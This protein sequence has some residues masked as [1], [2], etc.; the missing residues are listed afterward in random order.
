MV[1]L[2]LAL[3]C[4]E[5][6]QVKCPSFRTLL[7]GL[8]NLC[9]EYLRRS[10]SRK[11][12]EMTSDFLGAIFAPGTYVVAFN[13]SS[14]TTGLELFTLANFRANL[15]ELYVAVGTDASSFSGVLACPLWLK[16]LSF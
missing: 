4:G 11:P 16:T 2:I 14:I 13:F 7:L 15:G 10:F 8:F 12:S 5:V 1:A 3:T 6:T 9:A